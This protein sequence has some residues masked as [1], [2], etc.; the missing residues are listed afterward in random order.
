MLLPGVRTSTRT[1]SGRTL[2]SGR[3]RRSDK[4]TPRPAGRHRRTEASP[5]AGSGGVVCAGVSWWGRG[6]QNEYDQTVKHIVCLTLEPFCE[7]NLGTNI[8]IDI[9][10]VIS[11]HHDGCMGPSP[12]KQNE[13]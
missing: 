5:E 7:I 1:S 3:R 8:G 6:P 4:S 10:V 9:F 11:Q 2:S 12:V 13:H